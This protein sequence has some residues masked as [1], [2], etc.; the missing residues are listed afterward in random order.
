MKNKKTFTLLITLGIVGSAILSACQ[1]AANQT[2]PVPQTT[3]TVGTAASAGVQAGEDPAQV[4]SQFLTTLKQETSDQQSLIF[5]SQAMQADVESRNLLLDVVGIQEVYPSFDV[6]PAEISP[7]GQHA[8]VEAILNFADPIQRNFALI[9]ENGAWRINTIIA[10]AVPP[11]SVSQEDVAAAETIISFTQDLQNNDS[12]SAW[13][14]LTPNAQEPLTEAD[15][16]ADAK[17][18]KQITATTI[19]LVVADQ[20]R[21]V[22]AV[23]FWVTPDP[24]NPSDWVKGSNLRWFEMAPVDGNWLINEIAD[25]PIE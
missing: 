4:V 6:K 23:T 7:D 1:G 5:L 20:N 11:A 22:Y 2:T 13:S 19:D 14:L 8:M 21:L 15:I 12:S 9:Q 3:E 10:Y 18:A 25:T 24:A 17:G 16:E